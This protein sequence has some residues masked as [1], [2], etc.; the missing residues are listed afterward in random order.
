MKKLIGFLL[1][2]LAAPALAS[3]SP[4]V[5]LPLLAELDMTSSKAPLI[6]ITKK[7]PNL[8]YVG[9]DAEFEID[10]ANKGNAAAMNV[11]VTDALSANADFVSADNNGSRSGNNVVWNLGNMEPGASKTLKVKVR[12]NTIGKIT[13]TATVN[14]CAEASDGCELEVK[15]IP[16]ILIECVDDPDPI[17]VGG[18][19]TY[20]ITV[21][22][23]GSA[24][25]TNIALN[26]TLPDQEEYNSS[27]GP[28]AGKADG[29]KITFAPLASLAPK[30]TATY[31]VKV[32]G[33]TVGDARFHVEMKSD[34]MDSSVME[35][36]STHVY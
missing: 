1:G 15:G 8:R 18:L 34:Q 19:V 11:V 4:I 36:E 3:W 20:T 27:E 32:K 31:K 13:N 6:E 35:T 24:V 26:C 2:A 16:A 22:N 33:T 14:Y 30:A 28:T 21:T 10:V 7:C 12:C 5:T 23:Q 9:R 17:E 29:K 25:G